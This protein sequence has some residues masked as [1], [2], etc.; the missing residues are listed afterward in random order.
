VRDRFLVHR[1]GGDPP[2]LPQRFMGKG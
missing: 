1:V 2:I